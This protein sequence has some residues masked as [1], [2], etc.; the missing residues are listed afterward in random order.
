MIRY[1]DEQ[2]QTQNERILSLRTRCSNPA[3]SKNK[4][5]APKRL[6]MTVRKIIVNRVRFTKTFGYKYTEFL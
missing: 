6:A 1:V 5:A 3:Y 4:I 2:R